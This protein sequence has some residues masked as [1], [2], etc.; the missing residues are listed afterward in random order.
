MRL[1]LGQPPVSSTGPIER[2]HRHATETTIIR[3]ETT[4]DLRGQMLAATVALSGFGVAALALSLGHPAVAALITA[5]DIGGMVAAF[6]YG[7]R[8]EN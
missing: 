1:F 4:R 5:M 6:I 2:E 3:A 7:R 8:Q